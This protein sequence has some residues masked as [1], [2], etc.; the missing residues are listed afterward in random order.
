M[1]SATLGGISR[2]SA[3]SDNSQDG[4]IGRP[5]GR[6]PVVVASRID[7]AAFWTHG[8][9]MLDKISL[10]EKCLDI[11]GCTNFTA[12]HFVAKCHTVNS[13]QKSHI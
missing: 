9:T 8:R 5:L 1:S 13:S 3:N 4:S 11:Q 10:F 6:F 7:P 2:F 12:A